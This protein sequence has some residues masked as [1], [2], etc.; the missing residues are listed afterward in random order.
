M[1][2]VLV[3]SAAG[4]IG[5]ELVP[6]CVSAATRSWPARA[7]GPPLPPHLADGPSETVSLMDTEALKRIVGGIG[8]TP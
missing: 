3:I 5:S 7:G 4:Q 2:R 8:S 1:E 6:P